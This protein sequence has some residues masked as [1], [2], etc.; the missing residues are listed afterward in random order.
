LQRTWSSLTLGARPLNGHVVGQIREDDLQTDETEGPRF[1]LTL[2]RLRLG[3]AVVIQ[4]VGY[5]FLPD[6]T[7][8]VAAF[9]TWAPE[10]L[11]ELLARSKIRH[12]QLL[13][14]RLHDVSEQFRESVAKRRSSRFI[15]V[16]DY[17]KGAIQMAE[18]RGDTF[19]WAPGAPHT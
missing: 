18:L 13:F 6:G 7:L 11:D 14:E 16:W 1:E 12:A 5:S 17:G 3:H 19:N 10:N 15:L 8:E 4:G 9:S 2:E